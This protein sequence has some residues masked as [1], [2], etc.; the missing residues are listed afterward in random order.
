MSCMVNQ[1]DCNRPPVDPDIAQAA[2]DYQTALAENDARQIQERKIV[3]GIISRFRTPEDED[4]AA[5]TATQYEAVT[6]QPFPLILDTERAKRHFMRQTL[7]GI[8]FGWYYDRE[9]R[10]PRRYEPEGDELV[11]A[12]L[13]RDPRITFP[14]VSQSQP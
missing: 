12:L 2:L 13:D 3:L 11:R 8:S 14:R 9:K 1:Q 10:V 4:L 7:G 5:F 6:H